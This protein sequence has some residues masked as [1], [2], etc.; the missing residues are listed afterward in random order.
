MQTLR[1]RLGCNRG[2]DRRRFLSSNASEGRIIFMYL[3]MLALAISTGVVV[4]KTVKLYTN[5]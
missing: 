5:L 1:R 4:A 2:R 3:I